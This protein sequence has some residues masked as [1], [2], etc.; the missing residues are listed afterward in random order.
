MKRGIPVLRLM[1]GLGLAASSPW[2][3]AGGSVAISLPTL[4]EYALFGLAAAVGIAGAVA[5]FRRR[6]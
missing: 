1:L 3:W 5:V 2:T 4:D 6:R